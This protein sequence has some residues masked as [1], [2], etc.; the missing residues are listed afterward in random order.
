MT[1]PAAERQQQP[2]RKWYEQPIRITYRY[3]VQHVSNGEN[4]GDL[5]PERHYWPKTA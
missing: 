1:A 2:E 5:L 3:G 4:G